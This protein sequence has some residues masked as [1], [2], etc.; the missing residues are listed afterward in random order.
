MNKM[1]TLIKME[2]VNL[3]TSSSTS[4]ST[5]KKKGFRMMLVIMPAGLLLWL[6]CL[7]SFVLLVSVPGGLSHFVLLIMMLAAFMILFFF[8]FYN[9]Q[10]HLFGFK[11]YDLL[12]SLPLDKKEIMLSKLFAFL[13]LD[14][15]YAFFIAVPTLVLYAVYYPQGLS[16]Y[17]FAIIGFL[18]LPLIPMVISSLFAIL[19]YKISGNSR[20]RNLIQ[21]VL[22]MGLIALILLSSFTMP[23]VLKNVTDFTGVL[24]TIQTFVPNIYYFVYALTEGNFLY[25]LLSLLI[26]TVPFV[27]FVYFFARTF[28]KLN[29]NMLT[30]Y[31]VKN[32]KLGRL[33][34]QSKLKALFSKEL[35]RYFSSSLYVLNTAIGVLMLL[36]LSVG[37]L[38]QGDEI[39]ATLFAI[40]EI[41]VFIFPAC[42]I[43][44]FS[45]ITMS[46]TTGISISLEGNRLWIV[47]SLPINIKEYF[48]SK[49]MV[50]WVVIMP[51][52]ILSAFFI[53]YAFQFSF[54]EIAL[55]LLVCILSAIFT[56][57]FGLVVNLNFPKLQWDREVIV[58][59]QSI[60]SFLSIMSGPII[61]VG[62]GFLYYLF[63]AMISISNFIL[64]MMVLM[65]ILI[66]LMWLYLVKK[67]PKLFIR[68]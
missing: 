58:I 10:G 15:F 38:F 5:R 67:G 12:M 7:Y 61:G 56:S 6:S 13:L 52:S 57:L 27:L 42:C 26:N 28:T 32:Y 24:N 29:E 54:I 62:I 41:G 30:G 53:S 60:S 8:S 1:V 16:Y 18:T 64:L 3:F 44:F 47:K 17:L 63:R 35:R 40:P 65:V 45:L 25:F 39:F 37:A 43:L 68:L 46:C 19:I 21:N 20:F 4:F 59:K 11:D 55:L 33:H 23:S 36:I 51:L 22:S 14:Y 2:L 48:L 50:N 9:A 31:K 34:T 66:A 49:A